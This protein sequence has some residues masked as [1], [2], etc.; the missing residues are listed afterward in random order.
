M[1]PLIITETWTDR[2]TGKEK[3]YSFNVILT[4]YT[5][6][7]FPDHD[8]ESELA[9]EELGFDIY[10][11][12]L[13][14][15]KK[16]TTDGL[17]WLIGDSPEALLEAFEPH[18]YSVIGQP[19]EPYSKASFIEKLLEL[20]QTN[21]GHIEK[22]LNTLTKMEIREHESWEVG[23]SEFVDKNHLIEVLIEGLQSSADPESHWSETYRV[24]TYV[25]ALAKILPKDDFKFLRG[26]MWEE[27]EEWGKSTVDIS[28]SVTVLDNEIVAWERRY[29]V[30][31][32][33]PFHFHHAITDYCEYD[34]ENCP[35]VSAITLMEMF[36]WNDSTPEE[37]IKAPEQPESDE[38]GE[39]GVCYT[40]YE[41]HWVADKGHA[42][43]EVV[44]EEEVVPYYSLAD[45]KKAVTLSKAIIERQGEL[46]EYDIDILCRPMDRKTSKPV[47]ESN[48]RFYNEE[49]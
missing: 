25:D 42:R 39:Y 1:L 40:K 31:I 19:D 9:L 11:H 33:H 37:D 6:V 28:F 3:S 30:E 20:L 13:S 10:S 36:R 43:T 5:T 16:Y 34:A 17:N 22:I 45:A 49:D 26:K 14:F 23:E 2:K 27:E 38:D 47:D 46:K 29:D 18:G 8:I 35:P 24:R 21:E 15:Y 7:A 32:Y 12:E 41:T 4:G 48:W 44:E